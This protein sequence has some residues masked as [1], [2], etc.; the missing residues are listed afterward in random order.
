MAVQPSFADTQAPSRF[1][2]VEKLVR[3]CQNGSLQS[4][5]GEGLDALDFSQR[6]GQFL[7]WQFSSDGIEAASKGG[8]EAIVHFFYQTRWAD[9]IRRPQSDVGSATTTA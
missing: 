2:N 5:P 7:E 3:W 6:V 9:T 1:I 8:F 4:C